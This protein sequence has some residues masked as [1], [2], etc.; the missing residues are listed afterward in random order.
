M[1]TQSRTPAGVQS[2]FPMAYLEGRGPGNTGLMVGYQ[3]RKDRIKL[4]IPMDFRQEPMQ[5]SD[6]SYKVMCRMK[7]GGVQVT[8]PLSIRYSTGI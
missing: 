6:L 8:K 5:Q 2:V 3:K 4:H 7:T 1:K